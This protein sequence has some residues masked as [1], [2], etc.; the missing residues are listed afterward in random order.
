VYGIKPVT[1]PRNIKLQDQ[2][3]SHPMLLLTYLH[4]IT[5]DKRYLPAVKRAGEFYLRAQNPNG[6]W[7]HHYD[8][9]EG[10][11]ENG[12][13]MP[14]GGELN[15][16]ATN[17]AIDMMAL[18]YHLTGEAK[19]IRAMKRV[20]DWL[21]QAQ[22]DVVPLWSDQY[23][24]DNNPVWARHFEPPA[25]GVSATCL[26]CQGLRAV[27]RFSGDQRYLAGIRS[28]AE[29]ITA[30]LPEGRMSCFVDPGNGR[31]IAGWERKVYFLDEPESI[32]FLKT[33]PVGTGY[34][35]TS[36]IGRTVTRLL[37]QAEAGPPRR[38]VLIADAAMS[39]LAG[40]R[41]RAANAMDS[42]NEAGVWTVPVVANYMGSI[43]EGFGSNI[44]R[45]THM[46]AYVEAARI[47]TG[48]LEPRYPGSHN[49]LHLAYPFPDWYE[50]DWQDCLK[51]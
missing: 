40:K 50:V 9:V 41:Q 2:D 11:G 33:V 51:Q 49:M 24:A 36:N 4:R 42:R 27:Y 16:R 1:S 5:G 46:I 32:A 10:R 44:P 6:S 20:G 35:R 18:M 3:Q 13:G 25:Y 14:G 17:D 47:A 8:L 26:A 30:N 34:L 19:Y 43:G 22:G 48:E 45:A 37:E 23:D 12:L 31:A 28:A 15:D 29:W 7:S 39:A 21:L 38:E